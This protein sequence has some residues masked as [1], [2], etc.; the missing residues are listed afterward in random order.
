MNL[1]KIKHYIMMSLYD[2]L[3]EF[4]SSFML[5]L[6]AGTTLICMTIYRFL[7]LGF[8]LSPFGQFH[9]L[10]VNVLVLMIPIAYWFLKGEDNNG[11]RVLA[12]LAFPIFVFSIHDVAWLIETHFVEQ[13]FIKPI[14]KIDF[15]Q[16]VF[17]Y[18][19]NA[20][21]I[22]VSGALIWRYLSVNKKF[23]ALLAVQAVFHALNIVFKLDFYV[24]NGFA[25]LLMYVMDTTPYFF[26]LK[27]KGESGKPVASQLP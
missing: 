21:N 25:L 23:I 24:Q 27:V 16:Y 1:S 22:I 20:I 4:D 6:A 17:H 8:S 12:A 13:Q 26:L 7:G 15:S 5:G 11:K 9:I 2:L 3:K 14:P 19:K 10:S 18:A